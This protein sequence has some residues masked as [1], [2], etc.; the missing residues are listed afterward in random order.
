MRVTANTFPNSLLNQLNSLSQRQNKLQDQAATGQLVKLPEDDPVAMRRVLDMQAGHNA[1]A[2]HVV[3]VLSGAHKKDQLEKEPHT[4]LI[5]SVAD[6]PS[7]P[8]N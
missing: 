7:T 5:A 4:H 8:F 3:G 1:G 6:L 2:R